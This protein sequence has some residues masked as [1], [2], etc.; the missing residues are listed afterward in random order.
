MK[1]CVAQKMIN[2][3]NGGFLAKLNTIYTQDFLNISVFQC[4]FIRK[5]GLLR[6]KVITHLGYKNS[7]C[8]QT[9]QAVS[10]FAMLQALLNI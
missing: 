8:K 2:L 10:L 3:K 7:L 5:K 1:T 6:G 4:C 9:L